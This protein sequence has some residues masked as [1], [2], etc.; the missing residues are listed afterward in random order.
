MSDQRTIGAADQEADHLLR[1]E[2]VTKHYGGI[3]ALDGCTLSVEEGKITGLIGPNGSGKSTLFDVVCGDV[4]PTGGEVYFDDR[5]ITSLSKHRRHLLGIGRS[6]QEV[7]VFPEL[8]LVENVRVAAMPKRMAPVL[9]DYA[10][11]GHEPTVS[12]EAA[13]EYLESVQL[14]HLVGNDAEELSYGQQKLLQLAM[15]VA[16]GSELVLLDEPTAGV[17]PTTTERILEF[18][19]RQNEAGTTFLFVDHNVEAIMETCHT[20]HALDRGQVIA[21][22]D[23]ETVRNDEE[24]RESYLR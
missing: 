6:Y 8:T 12:E 7:E 10:T 16:T 24:V 11:P 15:T 5:R 13:V 1:T 9:G 17:N 3:V 21:T 18:V 22:G 14:D 20:I 19:R 23:A 2:D 4:H